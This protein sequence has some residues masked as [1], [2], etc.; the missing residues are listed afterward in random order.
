MKALMGMSPND[1]TRKIRLNRCMELLKGSNYNVTEAA[2]MT[3]FNNPG[4]FRERFKKEFGKSP[5][6]F[7]PQNK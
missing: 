6:A 7:I 4:N 3:G 1:Y 2:I 5:S